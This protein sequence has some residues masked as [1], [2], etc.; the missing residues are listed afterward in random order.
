MA[1][2][3]QMGE[4]LRQTS[5]S[6]NIRERL[7]FSCALFDSHGGLVA[8]APH[9]PVHLGSMGDSIRDLLEQVAA[10]VVPPLQPGDTLLSNDP[11]HGGTHLPDITA[12]TPVFCGGLNPSF[13]VASRGHHA[14]V[15]GISPGSMPSFSTSIDDEG[16]LLRNLLF[17][18]DGA[19]HLS[20]WQASFREMAIPPRN[21]QELLADLQAQVAANQAG[22]EGLEQL[23][24]REGEALVQ[25]Q[26]QGLQQHA[27]ACVRRL[28]SGLADTSH[29]LQ[30]DDGAILAVRIG[31]VPDQQKLVL[32]F[33]G[34][35]QQRQGNFNAPLSV[36]R[37]VVLYVIRCLLDDDIPLN[38][39]C[40]APLELRV[41]LGCML[42]PQ[43]PAAVVAGNV[44]VS[45]ALCNLL[46]GAFGVLAAGQ[47]TM[48]NLSFGNHRCQYYETVAGGGGAGEGFMGSIG[49]QS[50][51]TNSRL[52][53]PEVLEARYPVR[54]ERFG[55]R[56]GSGGDGCWRGGDGLERTI[57]FLEPMSL[58]LI[59]GSR[60]VAPF[61][62][63]GGT[64]GAC[65]EN[66]L[67]RAD[68]TEERLPGSVQLELKAGEA[69]QM[70]T[71]GGGGYGVS[72]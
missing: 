3:E 55:I 49:L 40:F 72:A 43:A 71:P 37:A 32:D 24:E 8:N 66:Q 34:T 58:S 70:L 25:Q 26:M 45:Q 51:M 31:V 56:S 67:I 19:I 61:G 12:I 16:L 28:I 21:P 27:A 57:R 10:G 7:D 30:L 1:I 46:F 38:E 62:L 20:N 23:V 5:R 33:R 9:I 68:G 41:P 2:A 60:R 6:V 42:N 35:S 4:R 53:D 65:G 11:F 47:G 13:F 48:N 69:I 15:G 18:R 64:S 44:E 63:E 52:T 17:V 22:I 50:H 59:S 29:Q 36:T 39:G 14:D 54:L